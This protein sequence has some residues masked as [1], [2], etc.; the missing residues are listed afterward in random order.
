MLF[1]NFIFSCMFL[2]NIKNIS[3]EKEFWHIHAVVFDDETLI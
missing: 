1:W 2:I 3:G